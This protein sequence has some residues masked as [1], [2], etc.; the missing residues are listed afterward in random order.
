RGSAGDD[1][2]RFATFTGTN[3][4]ERIDGGAGYNRIVSGA[5][6]GNMDF[7]NTELVNIAR[8]EGGAGDSQITGSQGNDVILGGAGGDKFTGGLGNDTYLLGRG[9]GGDTIIENDSTAGNTDVAQFLSGVTSDQIWFQHVGNNLEASIIGTGDKLV[10]KDW[11]LGS[12]NH[13]EQFKTTDGAK[14]LLDS[15]VENLVNAMASFAPPAAGQTTLPTNY[16]TNLASVIAANW[17]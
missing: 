15:N 13:V 8:I 9:S 3:T 14:T 1:I 16:Q 4:V 5:F 2:I 7:S 10:V 6:F 17:Q 12:A 11:Y